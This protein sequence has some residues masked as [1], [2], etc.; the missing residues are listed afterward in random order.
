MDLTSFIIFLLVGALAG[1]VAAS[2]THGGGLGLLLNMAVGVIGAYLGSW[3][4]GLFGVA[5]GGLI[6]T[7][8]TAIIGA[9]VLLLIVSLFTGLSRPTWYAR[10]YP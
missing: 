5:F 9:V 2:L 6:G 4:L 3:L 8:V 7:F 1:W 10:R